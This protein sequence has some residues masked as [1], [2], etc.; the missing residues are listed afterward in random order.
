MNT[1]EHGTPE[2]SFCML[3]CRESENKPTKPDQEKAKT[4]EEAHEGSQWDRE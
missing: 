1:C 4:W 2:D 3:C